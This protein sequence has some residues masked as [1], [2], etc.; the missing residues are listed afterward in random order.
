MVH[1]GVAYNFAIFSFE[2]GPDMFDGVEVWGVFG[3]VKKPATHGFYE[4]FCFL[5]LM[6]RGIVHDDNLTGTQRGQQACLDPSIEPFGIRVPHKSI[7][8][9]QRFCG[10]SI[11]SNHRGPLIF[12]PLNV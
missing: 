1:V 5:G 3:L 4:V 10:R 11:S 8:R 9:Q 7:R 6:K 12:L 2:V